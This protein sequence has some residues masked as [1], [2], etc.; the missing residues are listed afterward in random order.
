MLLH[1]FTLR[2]K[3]R[4]HASTDKL[5]TGCVLFLFCLNLSF[6]EQQKQNKQLCHTG[7]ECRT[8]EFSLFHLSVR[9]TG[10]IGISPSG[11]FGGCG[12]G[13]ALQL[14]PSESPSWDSGILGPEVITVSHLIPI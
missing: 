5:H 13:E 10:Y 6:E 14:C 8:L 2:T 11:R 1:Q 7:K 3:T 9:L 4:I 12:F